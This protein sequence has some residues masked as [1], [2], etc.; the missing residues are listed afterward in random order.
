MTDVETVCLTILI[1]WI[2]LMAV[3]ALSVIFYVRK[4]RSVCVKKTVE[5]VV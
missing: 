3:I 5:V 4:G 1:C 2:S